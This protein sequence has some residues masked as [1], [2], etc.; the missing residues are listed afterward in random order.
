MLEHEHVAL[1]LVLLAQLLGEREAQVVVMVLHEEA[2]PEALD[3]RVEHAR[4][5]EHAEQAEVEGQ[6]QVD[7]LLR[8]YLCTT[9]WL[10]L[11]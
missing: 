2:R 1:L 4:E 5:R 11:Y 10:N 9:K 3:D 8:E 6:Q 7:V